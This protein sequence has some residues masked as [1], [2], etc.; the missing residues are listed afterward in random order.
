[1]AIVHGDIGGAEPSTITFKVDTVTLTL[2][3]TAVH[4]EVLVIGDPQTS[5]AIATVLAVT[6]TST[7]YGQVVRIASGPSSGADLLMRPVFSSTSADN[8]VRAVLSSTSADNPVTATLSLG[9]LQ[10]SVAP[11]GGSSGLIVRIAGGPSS[12]VDLVMRPVFSSTNT[13]NPVRAVLSSTAADNQVTI[14]PGV[15]FYSAS[16]PSSAALGLHVRQV[17]NN[18]QSVAS[19]N[20][21]T[22]SSFS[23][24]S[25]QAALK[26][27]VYAYSITTT[28][29]S[30]QGVKF[31][32]GVTMLW[33]VVL[34]AVSSA[35]SGANLAV[36]PPSYL[37]ANSTGAALT[38][39]LA[40]SLAG[41]K[42]GVAFF[43]D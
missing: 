11:A 1:M 43:Q 3:S 21:F 13:D 6:P 2:N 25:S 20:A 10:S 9:T 34:Q 22:S 35:I 19:S 7:E 8:P 36:S 39:N 33:P 41:F 12:A 28:N 42:V 31:Y 17:L 37:F 4:R 5:N 24:A 14:T 18:L 26:T 30:A 40:S 38:L 29:V 15:P 16:A 32:N 23:V 27:K